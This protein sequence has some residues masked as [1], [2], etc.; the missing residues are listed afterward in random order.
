MTIDKYLQNLLATQDLSEKQEKDIQTHKAEV[1]SFLRTEFGNE[2]VI[3]YAG[4]K[5]KG[6]MISDRY[7]LDIVCYFPSSDNRSLKEIREDVA[8]RLA[9]KYLLNHKASAERIL[10]LKGSESPVDFHIDVVP[11]R[12]IENTK[13]VFLHV[14][15][16]DKERM[17]T[18]L[19]VHISHI[20]DSGCVPIIRLVKLWAYRN[21][22]NIKTFVLELFVV[23]VLSGYKDKGDLRKGF[24]KTLEEFK[25]NFSSTQLID[26]ANTNNIVSQLISDIEKGLIIDAAKKTFDNIFESED[27]SKWQ[28][29]FVDTTIQS[30]NVSPLAAGASY[31]VG[32]S[33]KPNKPWAA[34]Y[35]YRS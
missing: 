19:K 29:A 30:S 1:T 23:K 24:L 32:G 7:D 25:N 22:V 31:I 2:P 11:G 34:D 17:Q 27:I 14:A 13:D 3:K 33:F 21:N 15:Y 6:T 10:D 5:E 12:F 9:E 26:P 35:D 4:S 18:N 8:N 28:D 16:G 20:K